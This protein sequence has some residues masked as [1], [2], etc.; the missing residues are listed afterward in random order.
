M[1]RRAEQE[2]EKSTEPSEFLARCGVV[3]QSDLIHKQNE[4]AKREDNL[5]G[6][7]RT[8]ARNFIIDVLGSRQFEEPGDF[9]GA[10]A[11]GGVMANDLIRKNLEEFLE[12][13]ISRPEHYYN[14]VAI[15]AAVKGIEEKNSVV[16]NLE[17]DE[18]NGSKKIQL[19]L[20]DLKKYV[21]R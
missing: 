21:N 6:L 8:V 17:Q 2:A 16:F 4:G 1:F 11:T 14:I 10:I 13:P 3:I 9:D 20:I 12:I 15:G 18:W 5:S 19:K 7:Y